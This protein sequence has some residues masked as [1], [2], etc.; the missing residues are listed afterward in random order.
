M[1]LHPFVGFASGSEQINMDEYIVVI[2]LDSI[3]NKFSSDLKKG[4]VESAF[5]IATDELIK[6]ENEIKNDFK[7]VI[8]KDRMEIILP[9][10]LVEAS[11]DDINK[12]KN[13]EFVKEVFE[14]KTIQGPKVNRGN[15]VNF[16][17]YTVQEQY[18]PMMTDSNL[19]I[20]NDADTQ[21]K[22]NGAGSVLAIIDG[23]MDPS[24]EAFYLSKSVKARY[25]ANDIDDFVMTDSL[26]IKKGIKASELFRSDKIPFAY[27]YIQ[28]SINLNPENEK[29][30]HGQHVSGTVGGNRVRL[31]NKTWR[32]VAPESQLLMMNVMENGSTNGWTYSQAMQDAV[33]MK[34]DA[35]NM[36]LGSEKA[37]G[38]LTG[39]SN[40]IIENAFL[41]ETNFVIAAGNEGEYKGDLN[42]DNPDFG[43]ID[44]PGNARNAITVA[45]LENKKMRS[46]PLIFEGRHF[47]YMDSG[48]VEIIEGNYEYVD[49]GLG[50]P[51]DFKDKVLDNKIALIER[52][53]GIA[54][55]DKIKNA[56][57]AGA[58]GVI[59]YNNVEGM[60]RMLVS[61]TTIPSIFIERSTAEKM[62]KSE[63]K[64][65]YISGRDIEVDNPSYG[66]LS[67]F[68]NWG[69]TAGGFMKPD[70]T[71]PGGHIY[72]TETM[73]N[74]FGDMSGTSMATPHVTGAVGV[75]RERLKE[76]MF[77]G[78]YSLAN[79]TKTIL[80]NSAV[81]HNDP[82]TGA[83]TSPRRQGAGVLNIANAIKLDFTAVDKETG[84]PSKFRGDVQDNI[85]LSLKIKNWSKEDK[86]ITPSVQANIEAREGKKMLLRPEELFTKTYDDQS[87]T[88]KAGEEIEKDINISIENIEKLA[89]YKNGAFIDG[90]LHLKDQNGMEISFP[91]V[92]FRGQ[93]KNIPSIEKPV[94]EFNFE[95]ENPI[96]WN[97]KFSNNPW[98][99]FS[100]HIETNFGREEIDGKQ[101][102]KNVIAGVENFEE[103]DKN[104]YSE[105]EP[106]PKFE[107]IWLSPNRDGFYDKLGLY[108]VMTRTANV[109]YDVYNEKGEEITKKDLGEYLLNISYLP[110]QERSTT[111][112]YTS[113]GE[114]YIASLEEG[115]Y[116][117]NVYAKPVGGEQESKLTIPF[118]IDKVA[119]KITDVKFDK[120]SNTINFNI[121][122][123]GSGLR[124]LEITHNNEPVS[125][126]LE[127]NKL[128]FTLPKDTDLSEVNIKI[129]D[130]AYNILSKTAEEILFENEFANVELKMKGRDIPKDLEL[131][132][133]IRN[134]KGKEFDINKPFRFGKYTLEIKSFSDYYELDGDKTIEFEINSTD[135]KVIDLPFTKK[136]TKRLV[137]KIGKK[138]DLNYED[139]EVWIRN[140]D[141][142]K[143]TKLTNERGWFIP[144]PE[145][146]VINLTEGEYELFIKYLVEAEGYVE[147]YVPGQKVKV[148]IKT[149]L[150]EV[151]INIT[152]PNVK[153]VYGSI[154]YK[155]SEVDGIYKKP[156]TGNIVP[157]ISNLSDKKPVDGKFEELDLG[158]YT[159]SIPRGTFETVGKYDSSKSKLSQRVEL[160]EENKDIIV[161]FEFVLKETSIE[162]L[163]RE[164]QELVD[165]SEDIKKSS[166]YVYAE[167]EI[168]KA[169]DEAISKA[170]ETIKNADAKKKDYNSSISAIKKAKKELNGVKPVE[171][172]VLQKLVDEYDKVK[173]SEKYNRSTDEEKNNYNIAILKGKEALRDETIK[174]EKID[175]IIKEIEEAKSKLSG[176]EEILEQT[177]MP[178]VEVAKVN[179]IFVKGTGIPGATIYYSF[180]SNVEDKLEGSRVGHDGT[181]SIEVAKIKVGDIID[182]Y[183]KE[184]NKIISNPVRV[185]IKTFSR[186]FLEEAIKLADDVKNSEKHN[187]AD[188]E[189]KNKFDKELSKAKEALKDENLT[190]SEM[191]NIINKLAVL[192]SD[193]NGLDTV[194]H[195]VRFVFNDGKD[196]DVIQKVK[197][198]ETVKKIDVVDREGYSFDEWYADE[199]LTEKFDFETKI[200]SSISLYAKWN[201]V[202]KPIE[203]DPI[204]EDP[205]PEPKP[206]DP[207]HRY[208][209]SP[210]YLKN[211][212]TIVTRK[213]EKVEIE[214][215]KKAIEEKKDYGIIETAPNLEVSYND[216][217]ND[218]SAQAI[219]NMSSR[220]ILK[221]TAPG[222]FEPNVPISR[223]MVTTVLMRI[224]KDKTIDNS[225]TFT[226]VN[227]NEWYAEGVKW[228]A[229]H[230]IVKGYVD[231]SFKPNALV[232]RQELAVIIDRFLKERGIQME[233]N[234]ELTYNDIDALQDWSK[235]SVIRM[236]KA[237]LVKGLDANNY[238]ANS[239]FTRAE[240]AVLLDKIITWVENN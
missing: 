170:E 38:E 199:D 91:F 216:L 3:N 67:A 75:I 161:E 193:I 11:I 175:E 222:K 99:R 136:N 233:E 177:D 47:N 115:K 76:D 181:F 44:S 55:T 108:L 23:N 148:D 105:N 155:I 86:V 192:I 81:P 172:E 32:G 74:T 53:G 95:E 7:N 27:N 234:Q 131:E 25:N 139:V 10:I 180:D 4:D 56:T 154:E 132:Y 191:N 97:E 98:H 228:A 107:E 164:L 178:V 68:T 109:R 87:F 141:N 34:A 221:G 51:K 209:P 8:V 152:N 210:D 224:S 79:L 12:I 214:E 41:G 227:S 226:D 140:L 119:P 40:T 171:K 200:T 89:E 237:G 30:A 19:L 35:V 229:T 39:L 80:M 116:N 167:E 37:V 149:D 66:E 71:A 100:T 165:E 18:R 24:H 166:E 114:I 110:D 70:I 13:Y 220:G 205:I 207:G 156:Y 173:E 183:Q 46:K 146:W 29:A 201:K 145:K 130:K 134:E 190:E 231:G 78:D 43:T 157:F 101:M 22:Y 223:A 122:E 187:L 6:I 21:S 49:C 133:V 15:L 208:E 174:Q 196:Q 16:K 158:K 48:E 102:I 151:I 96:Y 137:A 20:G 150:P 50:L 62:L 147:E 169:Y 65:V 9:S 82:V 104:K 69:L 236:A 60:L 189:L 54:F 103:I 94:Y 88:L 230:G 26:K 218:L 1:I 142:K 188:Q 198:G 204:E 93:Y 185:Q 197:Y 138:A 106:K 90:F 240:L 186:K 159:V 59:V 153:T 203:E 42:I 176:I 206:Q 85:V 129:A 92:S 83:V 33:L 64:E 123:E 113:A 128:S 73:G 213:E 2:D 179:D 117:L 112:G 121:V 84:V 162:S 143:E 212:K 14:N 135:K 160:T 219:L 124:P 202:E 238:N 195:F 17:D 63:K 168:K 36:S 144:T 111:L 45:S 5:Q 182:I 215:P 58:I 28:N 163:K 217:P 61:G 120:D 235:E 184:R 72:S 194:E 125:Y 232:T 225:I 211:K 77:K 127:N 52:G 57:A 239:E 126:K 118:G 31:D